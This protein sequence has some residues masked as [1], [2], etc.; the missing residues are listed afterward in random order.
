VEVVTASQSIVRTPDRGAGPRQ[1]S[2]VTEWRTGAIPYRQ[3]LPP[4]LQPI[5]IGGIGRHP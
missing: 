2:R 5:S 4:M 1:H 3:L